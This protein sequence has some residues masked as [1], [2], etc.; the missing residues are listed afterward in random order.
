MY[1]YV[2]CSD[3]DATGAPRNFA[4]C[5]DALR[6]YVMAGCFC[7][8]VTHILLG[9][10]AG[11]LAFVTQPLC[12]TQ[13]WWKW[14]NVPPYPECS[15]Y[16]TYEYGC[17]Q[18]DVE[19]D[20]ARLVNVLESNLMF[21][22]LAGAQCFDT[23]GFIKEL[24]KI[25]TE[26]EPAIIVPYGIGVYKGLED[27][28]EYLG[29]SFGA[30]THNYWSSDFKANTAKGGILQVASDGKTW[31]N[32]GFFAGSFFNGLYNYTDVELVSSFT[33]LGC[34]TKYKTLEVAANEGMARVAEVFTYSAN[35]FKR[36]GIEDVCRYHTAYCADDPK[37]RQ[38]SSEKECLDFMRALPPY[39]AQCGENRP[40][41]GNSTTCRFKHH[42]MMP[43]NPELHCPHIG[44]GVKDINGKYKCD[45]IA[46]CS[47]P[48]QDEF[49]APLELDTTPQQFL[50]MAAKSNVGYQSEPLGCAVQTNG[51]KKDE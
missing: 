14:A 43:T 34:E 1:A 10:A 45:D 22:R 44:K 50:D 23:P 13:E 26:D 9:Q 48:K 36:Y 20:A 8:P 15:D 37:T 46:E 11:P 25:V 4:G 18:S 17:E 5:C 38:Y 30:L 19:M 49:W 47:D 31:T 28:A 21:Q 33:Y 7:N 27:M 41:A 35:Q 24:S 16:R 39:S 2:A 29:L 40:L 6:V 42:F 32:G 51:L 12:R 3:L